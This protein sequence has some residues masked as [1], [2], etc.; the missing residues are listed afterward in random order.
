VV[1]SRRVELRLSACAL[2]RALA[3]VAVLV[4]NARVAEHS[5]RRRVSGEIR[6]RTEG[7][8]SA[9]ALGCFS[10]LSVQ[11]EVNCMIAAENVAG[12]SG[13]EVRAS[14]FPPAS[15]RGE[16][17][18][19]G[20]LP[21]IVPP[22]AEHCTNPRVAEALASLKRLRDQHPFWENRLFKG[23]ESG[24][25]TRDD[26]KF[27]FS[28]YY[29]Y[30]RNFTRYISAAMA[31]CDDDYYR[32]K[33]TENLWEESGEKDMDRR[34]AQIFRRFLRDGMQIDIDNLQF[35]DC[36]QNFVREFLGFCLHSHPMASSAFLSLGTEG[37]V[38][39][40]YTSMVKGLSKAG[41]ES[42]HLEFFHIH[43]GCDDE[44]AETLENMMCSY[45]DEPDWY[46]TCARATEHALDL[47]QR[48]FENLIDALPR[49]R[50]ERLMA[51]VQSGEEPAIS[52]SAHIHHRASESGTPLYRNV[53]EKQGLE[54]RVERL[55]FG[56]E[57][58]DPRVVH[59]PAGKCNELHHHA[60]ETV[61]HIMKGSGKVR[62][63]AQQVEAR[64]GDTVFV[65]R[66]AMHRVENTGQD[67]LSYFAVTDF[68]FASKVH[69]G[70]YLEGH[71]QRREN[72]GSF[73]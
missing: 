67:E 7:T 31:N 55:P 23:C 42:K 8:S 34:H 43:I 45:F 61:I 72:D 28:Q 66:W 58:L 64:A 37:I 41:I 57:V 49:Q 11:V 10:G 68:G 24:K 59:I 17:L 39:R 52:A 15:R 44:H 51:T 70:D 48:F 3:P 46:N 54:F 53:D 63:G 56:A 9:R 4:S 29:F 2:K 36:T 71:R 20:V 16:L 35:I 38:S 60:H 62:V 19:E 21:S 18:P 73:T 50:V 47:R 13:S 6:S 32:S 5:T 25:L 27:I 1:V 65:P 40:M 26:F 22:S 69:Q 30:S 33:L 12:I 14:Q